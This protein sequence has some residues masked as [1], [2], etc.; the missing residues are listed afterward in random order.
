LRLSFNLNAKTAK[1]E[2]AKSAKIKLFRLITLY[3]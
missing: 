3:F 1:K 2:D